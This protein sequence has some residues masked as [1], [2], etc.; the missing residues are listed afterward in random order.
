MNQ[1]PDTEIEKIDLQ[2]FSEPSTRERSDPMIPV[3]NKI[4][5]QT[6]SPQTAEQNI[7]T[8]Y[9]LAILFTLVMPPLW[10]VFHYI[11]NDNAGEFFK[12]MG[13]SFIS[14]F[15]NLTIYLTLVFGFV[16]VVRLVARVPIGVVVF[17]ALGF[18]TMVSLSLKFVSRCLPDPA[19]FIKSVKSS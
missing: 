12:C 19:E 4:F 5:P 2:D 8:K 13:I 17:R 3:L 6:E 10:V 7:R 15:S 16:L 1:L 14:T 11:F 18:L 9:T